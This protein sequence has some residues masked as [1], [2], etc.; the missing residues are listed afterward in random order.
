M[1]E[2]S[3]ILEFFFWRIRLH[4]GIRYRKQRPHTCHSFICGKAQ[5]LYHVSAD[6]VA[7]PV[8][9]MCTVYPSYLVCKNSGTVHIYSSIGTE[10][11]N[12]ALHWMY[13]HACTLIFMDCLYRPRFHSQRTLFIFA[14][15]SE[16]NTNT[17]FHLGIP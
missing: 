3:I 9:P 4:T 15:F 11:K 14:F 17:H 12:Q 6:H 13:L 2:V 8:D 5:P 7:G 1:L 10:Q 16:T